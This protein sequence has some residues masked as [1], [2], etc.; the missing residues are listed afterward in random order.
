MDARVVNVFFT[1][2]S[3]SYISP[4]SFFKTVI[5]KINSVGLIYLFY[6]LIHMTH[7]HHSNN[8][9]TRQLTVIAKEG[10]IAM[11]RYQI[12]SVVGIVRLLNVLSF[13]CKDVPG[14][15]REFSVAN[16]SRGQI[17]WPPLRFS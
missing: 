9:T 16:C 14:F 13:P 4:Y 6:K 12:Y 10:Q 2:R 1:K 8:S 3:T 15:R 5:R 7:F 11:A 17:L